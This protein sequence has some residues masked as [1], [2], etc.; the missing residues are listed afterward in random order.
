LDNETYLSVL[1]EYVRRFSDY[2]PSIIS[3]AGAQQL[4]RDAL[5]RGQ[6]IKKS[7]LTPNP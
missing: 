5:R 2:P 7:D 1:A 6:P 3:E 4:M